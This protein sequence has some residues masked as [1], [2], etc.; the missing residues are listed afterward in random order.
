MALCAVAFGSLGCGGSDDADPAQG[1]LEVD[2]FDSDRAWRLVRQQVA[3]GQRPAGSQQLRRLAAELRPLLP[4]GR[5]EPVPGEPGLRNIVG[6]LPGKRPGIVVGAHYD[7]LVKPKGFVGANN[8]AAGTA[9]VIE[10]ARAVAEAEQMDGRREVRFVLFDGEEPAVGLPE[11]SADFYHSGLR[12][13][14]AYVAAHP[15]RTAAMVLLDYVGNKGLRL[16]REGSSNLA[17]WA[18]LRSAA[19]AVGAARFFPPYSGQTIVDDHTPFLRA[20]V[21]AV[22][23]IDWTYPGHDLSDGLDKLSRRSLD[24]VGETVVEL[25]LRLRA[26]ADRP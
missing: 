14:R 23:L 1:G 15:D 11:E 16:P 8:G 3:V 18:R 19:R 17:L 6:T 5:F 26:A 2:R 7:T 24:A 20:G 13:S 12:G 25:V 10:A 21:P 4:D 22:D 9:V